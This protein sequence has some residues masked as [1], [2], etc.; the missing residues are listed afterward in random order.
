MTL[1]I[2]AFSATGEVIGLVKLHE[3]AFPCL[4][5]CSSFSGFDKLSHALNGIAH[6]M[7]FL[8]RNGL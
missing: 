8:S 4:C 7:P 3:F 6:V 2:R 1:P 5:G